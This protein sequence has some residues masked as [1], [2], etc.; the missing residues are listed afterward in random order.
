M[1]HEV[2][3]HSIP[4]VKKPL[5]RIVL[6]PGR[7]SFHKNFLC[8]EDCNPTGACSS[9]QCNSSWA[10]QHASQAELLSAHTHA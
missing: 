2:F 5:L 6:S 9:H 3:M 10:V 1:A 4:T 7:C 8:L